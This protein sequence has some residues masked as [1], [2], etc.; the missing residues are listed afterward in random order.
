VKAAKPAHV[1][2]CPVVASGP[3]AFA[4]RLAERLKIDLRAVDVAH[5]KL[6]GL[7]AEG[8]KLPGAGA[9]LVQEAANCRG[10][11][12]RKEAELEELRGRVRR[13]VEVLIGNL[14]TRAEEIEAVLADVDEDVKVEPLTLVHQ[15]EA[16]LAEVRQAGGDPEKIALRARAL[17]ALRGRAVAVI[18]ERRVLQ[19][20]IATANQRTMDSLAGALLAA[21]DG[22]EARVG[23]LTSDPVIAEVPELLDPSALRTAWRTAGEIGEALGTLGFPRSTARLYEAVPAKVRPVVE[24]A[25][26]DH[27]AM[28]A[29]I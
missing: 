9:L 22:I 8:Q 18:E 5:H 25:I 19:A 10:S 14:K 24:R 20:K 17:A 29:A 12:A 6:D 15:A 1:R 28:V 26:G 2:G 23:S 3:Y 21:F 11:A 16:A 7:V 4:R 27:R 13:E